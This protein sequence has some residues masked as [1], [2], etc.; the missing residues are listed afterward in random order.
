MSLILSGTDGLSD[1]DGSAATPAIRG[2][3]ANTGIFFPAADTI[4]F[5][6]GGVEAMRIDSSGNLGIGT[7]SIAGTATTRVEVNAASSAYNLSVS[8]S[9]TGYLYADSSAF[10][11]YGYANV[12]LIIKTNNTERMRINSGA[13]ILCLSGGST[14]ATG[15]GIAFPATQS[16]SSDANTL[17]DYEEG[18]FTPTIT[19]AGG[20]FTTLSNV[21]GIYTKTGNVV[22]ISIT[23]TITTIG[24]ASGAATI[25]NLPFAGIANRYAGVTRE[26]AV[27][28]F[29]GSVYFNSST[30][31]NQDTYNGGSPIVAGAYWLINLQYYA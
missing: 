25:G 16:A 23:Y 3:D 31:L 15:T 26:I 12:P 27:N 9:L 6:E 8:G 10:G 1:V 13:P 30:T 7:S 28:G 5:S 18:S 19:P 24:T 22:N 17:D 14:T 4:A 2:T 29:G 21:F 11:L 20:A